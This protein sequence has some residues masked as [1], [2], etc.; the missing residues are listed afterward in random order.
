MTQQLWRLTALEARTAILNGSLSSKEVVQ[1]ALDRIA[2]VNPAVNALVEVDGEH[3]LAAADRADGALRR[4]QALGALHGLPVATKVNSDQ[5]GHATTDGVVEF[6]DR[7]AAED[8][9]VVANLRK[10]GAVIVGRTNTPAFSHNWFTDND[11]YGATMNPWNRQ[12]TP[13]GSSGG[14]AAAI[15]TGMCALAQGNDLGGSVRFPAFA[16]GIVGLRPTVGRIPSHL[17]KPEPL[18]RSPLS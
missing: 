15:A 1:A 10:A 12:L 7:V 14:A 3:A 2:E 6:R 9:P 4:G 5:A 17:S 8:S 18:P 16:C 11:L 13:G